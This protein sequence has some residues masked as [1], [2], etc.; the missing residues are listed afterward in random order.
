MPH[1]PLDAAA[2]DQLFLSART[3]G[4]THDTW[5]DKPVSA[6][7]LQHIWELA[8]LGPTQ[9]NLSPAR[10]AW[11]V[12]PEAKARL[13]PLM[14]EGNQN[15]TKNAPATAI[16][17]M[18]LAFYEKMPY[19]FPHAD[20][21]AWF[22]DA[23]EQSLTTT[24]LRNSSLQGAYL[25]MAARAL[26]LDCGPMLGFDANKVADEFFPGG[27]IRVNFMCNIGYGN[28]A[29]LRARHPRLSFDEACRIF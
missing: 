23:S 15:K 27:R 25:I 2:L 22:E 10:I 7:Q 6:E 3:F 1:L 24:V 13:F 9:S 11:V 8:R 26:G 12:S 18:D 21:R 4:A 19:L 29:E 14:D 20:G 5:L 16:I 28:R 17:G